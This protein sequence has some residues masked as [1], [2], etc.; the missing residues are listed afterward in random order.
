M[1][2]SNRFL[3]IVALVFFSI[4]PTWADES[5]PQNA[6]VAPAPK[7]TSGHIACLRTDTHPVC[8]ASYSN[9]ASATLNNGSYSGGKAIVDGV[10]V[11][12][13]CL[14]GNANLRIPRQC[15]W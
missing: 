8:V 14:P 1:H 2:P 15:R 13:T 9:N 10:E 12:F 4:E 11:T 6:P 5:N 7:V 3:V